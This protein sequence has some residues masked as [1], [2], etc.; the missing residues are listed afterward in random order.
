MPVLKELGLPFDLSKTTDGDIW[1][2]PDLLDAHYNTPHDEIMD[3]IAD[4]D[5]RGMAE[6]STGSIRGL[7]PQ[8]IRSANWLKPT[9]EVTSLW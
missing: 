9:P 3:A 5:P 8:S 6:G 4:V 1:T 7:L 2:N